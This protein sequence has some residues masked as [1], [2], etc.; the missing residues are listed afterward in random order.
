ME[1]ATIYLTQA[2]TQSM[3]TYSAANLH[4]F[5][6]YFF[7][8]L[9]WWPEAIPAI[10]KMG[11]AF[12]ALLSLV[13]AWKASRG[14]LEPEAL[15]LAALV[16]ALI[17]PQFLP[18][19]HNRYFFAADVLAIVL[20]LW[21]PAVYWPAA[22]LM[23]ASSFATYISFLWG[24]QLMANPVPSWLA[25]FGFTNNLQPV[26]GLEALAGIANFALLVWC[27]LRLHTMLR[28]PAEGRYALAPA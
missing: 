19:M 4:F 2:S 14:Q 27:W 17:A 15:L 9:G 21:R 3:L 6:H 22:L 12:T 24:A 18:Y 23:Q 5:P 7:M 20:A 16:S 1:V 10:A 11:V 13:F 26:T 25:F 8:H 28:Q